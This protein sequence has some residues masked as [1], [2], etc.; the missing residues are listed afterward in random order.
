M[1]TFTLFSLFFFTVIMNKIKDIDSALSKVNSYISYFDLA[2][3]I[4]GLISYGYLFV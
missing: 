1:F 2:N 3:E 4:E